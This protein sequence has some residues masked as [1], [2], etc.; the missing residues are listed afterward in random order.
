V[1]LGEAG[2][3]T[4]CF[5]VLSYAGTVAVTAVA[6]PDRF[7]DLAA[8]AA[9]LH[10]E[11]DLVARAGAVQPGPAEAGLDAPLGDVSHLP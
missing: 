2:N 10:D 3:A 6:D 7:P 9:A 8:L 4:V 1:G 5:E 11:L